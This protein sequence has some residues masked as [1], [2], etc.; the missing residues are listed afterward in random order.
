MPSA[1]KTLVTCAVELTLRSVTFLRAS[2]SFNCLIDN[3]ATP[4]GEPLFPRVIGPKE[5]DLKWAAAI[6]ELAK[7]PFNDSDAIVAMLEKSELLDGKEP[8]P[9]AA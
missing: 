4:N 9:T 8:A 2:V 7:P 3:D 6:Y 1:A 5:S